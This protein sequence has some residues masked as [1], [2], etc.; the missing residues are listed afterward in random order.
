MVKLL[1]PDSDGVSSFPNIVIKK[2]RLPL[3][4]EVETWVR[5]PSMS[6]SR[7]DLI[8]CACG[9]QRYPAR[10]AIDAAIFRGELEVNWKEFIEVVESAKRS[11]EVEVYLTGASINSA[12][13]TVLYDNA[14]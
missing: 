1:R 8:V 5:P 7:H 4:K 13:Y 12:S 11:D 6:V 14:L 10:D 3:R 9:K 2:P